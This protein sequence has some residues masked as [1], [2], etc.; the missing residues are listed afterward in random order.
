MDVMLYWLDG[1]IYFEGYEIDNVFIKLCGNIVKG[2]KFILL[3]V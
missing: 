1:V 3:N 2:V